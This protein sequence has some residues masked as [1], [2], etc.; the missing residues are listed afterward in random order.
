MRKINKKIAAACCAGLLAVAGASM[1]LA[2]SPTVVAGGGNTENTGGPSAQEENV[3]ESIRIWGTV[4]S[5]EDG[6]IHIDNQSGVSFEGEIILNISDEMTRILDAENG[7][8]VQLSDIQEGEVIYAYIGPAMTMS[9]PPQ[10]TPEMIICKIPADFKA[11]D[12][13][14]V[15]SMTWQENG[16]W[17]LVST[18]GTT[19][20]VPGNCPI[21][22][23]LTRNMVTL[24]DVVESSKIMIWSDTDNNAHK[25][26]L[27]P[28]DVVPAEGGIQP[29]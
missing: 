21:I 7:F 27:F 16:D 18:D 12:Y 4:M 1:A 23:Y 8:P 2:Q 13:A 29:Y 26:V 22:P 10:T 25:L 9:L 5:V 20:Q 11:P 6:R 19:Y 17:V 24:Q 28:Q 15:K 14:T 3:M